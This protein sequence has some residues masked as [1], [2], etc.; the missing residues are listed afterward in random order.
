MDQLG[1]L[2]LRARAFSV[3]KYALQKKGP[4]HHRSSIGV[5]ASLALGSQG[6]AQT[7]HPPK[8]EITAAGRDL[9]ERSCLEAVAKRQATE[10]HGLL[11]SS[12][13]IAACKE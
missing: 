12:S 9:M 7:R 6:S 3:D 5:Q 1:R 8:T 11:R 4:E 13:Q 2:L 10:L